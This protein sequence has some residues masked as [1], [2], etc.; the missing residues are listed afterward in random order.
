LFLFFCFFRILGTFR[1]WGY[2]FR[3]Y[4]VFIF[5][6]FFYFFYLFIYFFYV[7]VC[8]GGCLS[9]WWG[10]LRFFFKFNFKVL[11]LEFKSFRVARKL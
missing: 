2:F 7:R 4:R 6:L 1:V 11:F 3:L 8:A 10:C 9:V 5:F